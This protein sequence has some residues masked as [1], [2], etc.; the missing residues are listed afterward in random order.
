M[1]PG[2]AQ[3]PGPV[4]PAPLPP[5][6]P[7]ARRTTA[8]L[9]AAVAGLILYGS[10][11]PFHWIRPHP[12][13]VWW[14][15]GNLQWW[16]GRADLLGNVALFLP[17]G[18]VAA[19][20]AQQRGRSPGAWALGGGLLL[21]L[22]GQAGQFFEAHRD[23]RWADVLWNLVGAAAGR[24]A[25]AVLP[26][27]HR[28]P[29]AAAW[30]LLAGSALTAWL[31]LWP[32]LDLARL[33]RHWARLDEIGAWQGPEAAMMAGLTLV[34]GSAAAHLR[35]CLHRRQMAVR[36]SGPDPSPGGAPAGMAD[37][38]VIVA[39]GLLIL[40]GQALVPGSRF[41]AG[42]VLGGG[43]GLGLALVLW[44]RPRAIAGALVVLQVLGGL[45]PFD[46]QPQPV[47]ALH[48]L[49]FE[50]MLGGSM[51]GNAQAL[52]RDL[53]LWGCALWFARRGGWPLGPV[54]AV[55]AALAL[56]VEAIQCWMPSRTADV[57]PALIV[58]GLGWGLQA[59]RDAGGS[60]RR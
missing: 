38:A 11:F 29:A 56:A 34:A 18:L 31:P 32:A 21:A 54:T 48:W 23:P 5:G 52:A 41:S 50:A 44:R 12:D 45:A 8:V 59:W 39:T 6:P 19:L 28:H 58:L 10:W 46:L 27:A 37:A 25:A 42:G 16:T 14:A 36:P 26:R 2:G 3:N 1:P 9:C 57:T 60:G 13:D 15:L 55:C 20:A 22:A 7:P 40:G 53:W 51:R 47:Q 35:L 33:Q 49:P 30:T 4:T 24:W 17:W 43:L